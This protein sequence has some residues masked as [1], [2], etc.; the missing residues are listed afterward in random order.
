VLLSNVLKHAAGHVS[1]AIAISQAVAT[2]LQ[3]VLPATPVFTI[4]NAIDTDHFSPAPAD[5]ALLDQLA[6]LAPAPLGTVRVGLVATYARWKGQDVFLDAIAKLPPN[7]CARFYIVGGSIYH[8]AGSQ[9]TRD[10]LQARATELHVND[11]LGFI[12]F[13]S[14]PLAVYRAL[15]VIVHASSKPEPFGRTIVEAMACGRPVIVSSS[16]G[17]A[18]L[19]TDNVDGV[20]ISP[21]NADQLALALHRLIDHR[22]QR[23]AMAL[24][25]RATAV[26]RFN[27]PRLGP[28]FLDAYRQL[29]ENK[30]GFP[31]ADIF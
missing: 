21:G 5:A 22:D 6:Q 30:S 28:E 11:K 12:D 20:G 23:G 16:G 14:D 17:A 9:F 18:E 31:A 24:A 27:R 1:G 15:D 8:T 29:L 2:D 13:Q 26:R 25:A 3:K 10:E 4:L 7:L 19:F